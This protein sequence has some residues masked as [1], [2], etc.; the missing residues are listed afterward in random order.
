MERSFW[1][2]GTRGLLNLCLPT[3]CPAASQDPL[4]DISCRAQSR[5]QFSNMFRPARLHRDVNRS[6]PEVHTVVGPVVR[7]LHQIS[8]MLRQNSRQSM[9]RSRVIRQMH[10]QPYQPAIFYQAAFDDTCQQ[11]HVDVS[12]TD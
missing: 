9:Q 8:S 6:V 4:M 2:G 10:P 5:N 11:S 3:P 1:N 7:S 12:S